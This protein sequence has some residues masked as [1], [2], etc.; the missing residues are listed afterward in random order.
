MSLKLRLT[1]AGVVAVGLV[2]LSVG[3]AS[4]FSGSGQSIGPGDKVVQHQ[5]AAQHRAGNPGDPGGLI[6]CQLQPVQHLVPPGAHVVYME[7]SGE[8]QWS[9]CNGIAGTG[10]LGTVAVD[11]EFHTLDPSPQVLNYANKSLLRLG[12][13]QMTPWFGGDGKVWYGATWLMRLS[14]GT[15]AQLTVGRDPSHYW[16]IDAEAPAEGPKAKVSVC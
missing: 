6:L 1:L 4:A 13:G 2:A 12:W 16:N 8:P 3:V 9:T 11:G 15:V 10:S 14:N 7:L 5:C